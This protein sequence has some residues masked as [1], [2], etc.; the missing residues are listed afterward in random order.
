MVYTRV[1]IMAELP[2]SY[3]RKKYFWGWTKSILAW[4][5]VFF[6]LF[7]TFH[8]SVQLEKLEKNT[9]YCK[10][11]TVGISVMV[12]RPTIKHS[13]FLFCFC[14]LFNTFLEINNK[15]NLQECHRHPE[16]EG[17]RHKNH[18]NSECAYI[19][20]SIKLQNCKNF[21]TEKKKKVIPS[22]TKN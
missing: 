13:N 2:T 5:T 20:T 11:G 10:K 17:R 4:K 8:R 7:P 6:I 14:F 3:E 22:I 1:W 19:H 15:H 16:P 12:I 21:Q 18:I 9:K